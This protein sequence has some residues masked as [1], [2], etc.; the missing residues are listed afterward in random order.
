MPRLRVCGQ[1]EGR[2]LPGRPAYS[3]YDVW[4]YCQHQKYDDP[5]SK[6]ARLQCQV[7]N[8]A[9]GNRYWERFDREKPPP[10]PP[11]VDN[12]APDTRITSGDRSS[13][14][15][16]STLTFSFRAVDP[17]ESSVYI[18]ADHIECRTWGFNSGATWDETHGKNVPW[19]PCSDSLH[20]SY[21]VSD[22]YH[23]TFQ[24][25]AVDHAGNVDRTNLV[26]NP[27]F[28]RAFGDP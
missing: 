14:R 15:A 18:G 17:D 2:S 21:V 20:H 27:G 19:G 13:A 22:H 8:K 1:F 3:F 10:P 7:T 12:E 4:Y 6:S 11:P 28:C 25:R 16:G 26:I 24:V 23:Q 5:D 9:T